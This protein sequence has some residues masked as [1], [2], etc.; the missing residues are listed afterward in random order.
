MVTGG[1]VTCMDSSWLC[2]WTINRQPQFK[3]QKPNETII[4]FYSLFTDR[5]GDYIKKPMR[6]CTGVEVCEEWLYQIEYPK[7]ISS[8]SRP[9]M[10][11]PCRL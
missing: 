8:T 10:R 7:A 1:I 9:S 6:D 3:D 5:P 2:S 11:T 4:W